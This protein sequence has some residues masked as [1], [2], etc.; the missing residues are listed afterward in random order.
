MKQLFPLFFVFALSVQAQ[1]GDII[2][3]NVENDAVTRFLSEVKYTSSKDASQV[4]A[5]N[6]AP[7]DRRDIPRPAIIAIPD[8]DAETLLFTYADDAGYTEGVRTKAIAKG[9]K[10]YQ[11]YNLTPQRDY[12]FKVEADGN[13]LTSGKIHTEGQVRM[14]YVPGANNIRDLGG[15]PTVDGQRIKYGKLFRGGEVNGNHIVDSAGLAILTND[16]EIQA[17]IDMRAWYDEGHG[18]SAFGFTSNMWGNSTNPPYYYTS[19]SGQLPDHLQ[20]KS[21]KLKWKREF[22]FIIQNF[23]K[24]RN[25]YIHCV[26]GADRTGYLVLFME[27]VLG[28]D[29]NNMIKDY[30]LTNFFNG[31]NTKETIDTIYNYVMTLEGATPQEKFNTFL[32]DSCGVAQANVDYFRKMMLEEDNLTTAI[33]SVEADTRKGQQSSAVARPANIV[34][35]L[36]R[37]TTRAGRKGMVIEI[38]PDGTG[39]KVMR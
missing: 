9:S 33:K 29:Y 16:L 3:V 27:G 20:M 24:N 23:I 31:I 15:W 34:D 11:L 28:V 10:E 25:V 32:V 5:Y 21:N 7:P 36:G 19:D 39:R 35:L 8:N 2:N 14:I 17:E 37:K 22:D 13:T 6:V 38:L 4:T 12:Y 30:E 26:Q 1:T 18:V